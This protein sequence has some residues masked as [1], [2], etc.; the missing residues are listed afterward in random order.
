VVRTGAHGHLELWLGFDAFLRLDQNSA[1]AIEST[2]VNK[3]AVRLDSGSA[4]VEVTVINKG[5]IITVTA[6]DL[7]T[8]IDSRGTYRFSENT[9]SVL[10]GKLKTADNS[11]EVS[12]GWQIT[13]SGGVYERTRL[14]GEIEG[15]FKRYMSSPKAGFIN[16]VVGEANIGLHERADEDQVV[17]T[18]PGGHLELLLGPG[19]FLRLAENSS[20][21]IE[22]ND[23]IDTVLRVVSGEALIE[24]DVLD[25][26]LPIRV[27]VGKKK[28]RIESTGLYRFT[29]DTGTVIAGALQVDKQ[30]YRIFQGHKLTADSLPADEIEADLNTPPDELARWSAERSYEL[31]AANFMALFGDSRPNFFLYQRQ[32]PNNAAWIY[33]PSLKGFTFIPR[34]RYETYYD[35][36]FV[37]LVALLPPPEILPAPQIPFPGRIEPGRIG[38]ST[39]PVPSAA[40][41]PAPTAAP[42]P[43]PSPMPAPA[44]ATGQP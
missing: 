12:K 33:S 26:R 42:T 32:F 17:Q 44:P 18:G 19:S 43:A 16:A 38:G 21:V 22:K 6:G 35:Y 28:T 36:T 4:L 20:V 37:P 39:A 23:F 2:E 40:P 34:R 24:T 9:A 13:K 10:N 41:A 8:V 15:P 25:P 1:A 29:P 3:V 5:A 7:K 11:D 27:M 30:E 31:A 14:D